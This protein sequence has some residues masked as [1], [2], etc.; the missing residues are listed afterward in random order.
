MIGK[1][2][3][4]ARRWPYVQSISTKL[5]QGEAMIAKRQYLCWMALLTLGLL[6]CTSSIAADTPASQD[7][8]ATR[9]LKRLVATHPE[10]KRQLIDSIE[11]AKQV[12]PDR[13][14]NPAQTL[15]QFFEFVAW[16]ERAIPSKL[17]S[18]KPD[19][20]LY[21]RMDQSLCYLFF[22]VD[23]PLSELEGCGYFN[24]FV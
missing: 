9:E 21:Q 14:T 22:I 24:N 6:L 5:S 4:A 12:N 7:G 2:L 13:R 11:R 1:A 8:L 19:A 23:Q 18:A 17:I 16:T 10:L 3:K 20:T 15:E